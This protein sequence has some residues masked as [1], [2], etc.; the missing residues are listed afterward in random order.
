M[1]FCVF[2]RYTTNRLTIHNNII[3]KNLRLLTH[4]KNKKLHFFSFFFLTF[5]I[6]NYSSYNTISHFFVLQNTKNVLLKAVYSQ[7][8]R[9]KCFV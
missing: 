2:R 5:H 8:Y 1:Q 6:Q 7:I 4:I 3:K 9:L